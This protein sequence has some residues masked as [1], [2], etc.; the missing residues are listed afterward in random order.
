MIDEETRRLT[1]WLDKLEKEAE[2]IRNSMETTPVGR[3][4]AA[5]D[6]AEKN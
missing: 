2:A 5:R 6:E 3:K 4:E 1:E